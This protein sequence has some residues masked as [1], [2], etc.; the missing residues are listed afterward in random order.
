M[1]CAQ[2][3]A[4][5][6]AGRPSWPHRDSKILPACAFRRHPTSL[7]VSGGTRRV[8]P[9]ERCGVARDA[10]GAQRVWQEGC[11]AK[12]LRETRS[13]TAVKTKGARWRLTER[14]PGG[15]GM[16]KDSLWIPAR[17]VLGVVRTLRRQQARLLLENS[18]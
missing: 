15:V 5:R 16:N 9:R 7:V 13:R 3:R 17:A 11:F 1:C 8:A 10:P 18:L 2:R 14:T 4:T 12:K 6:A